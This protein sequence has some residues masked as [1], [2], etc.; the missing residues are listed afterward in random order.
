MGGDPS[1]RHPRY[2]YRDQIEAF[3]TGYEQVVGELASRRRPGDREVE[4][5]HEPRSL[6]RHPYVCVPSSWSEEWSET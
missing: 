1:R 4:V 3:L 2:L 6:A 5:P